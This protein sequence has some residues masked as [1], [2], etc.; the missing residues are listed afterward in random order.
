M[1][2]RK[3][4]AEFAI[5]L[6]DHPD[7]F[8]MFPTVRNE[9]PSEQECRRCKSKLQR[10]ISEIRKIGH[11]PSV[12]FEAFIN[13]YMWLGSQVVGAVKLAADME[14]WDPEHQAK[15]REVG[16]RSSFE[17]GDEEGH[18]FLAISADRY[19]IG[20][21]GRRNAIGDLFVSRIVS[22]P[23]SDFF[24]AVDKIKQGGFE[25]ILG[26]EAKELLCKMEQVNREGPI[27]GSAER[28]YR[29]GPSAPR[30]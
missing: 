24:T 16:L 8:P 21:M 10:F 19:P 18:V 6:K 23:Y 13:T 7:K 1:G 17:L 26:P 4:I 20:V 9:V 22:C 27:S 11:S 28:I 29:T 25:L 2:L 12:I 30:N 3:G 14:N 15:L 5:F